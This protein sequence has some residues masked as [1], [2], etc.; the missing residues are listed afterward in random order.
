MSTLTFLATKSPIKSTVP[1]RMIFG[2]KLIAH[3][4]TM[5]WYFVMS[6]RF[7]FLFNVKRLIVDRLTVV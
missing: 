2:T 6:G 7:I 4:M 3:V 5:S 1:A